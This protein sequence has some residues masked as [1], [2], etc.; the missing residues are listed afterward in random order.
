MMYRICSRCGASLDPE[1]KCDCE[2]REENRLYSDRE[3]TERRNEY[4]DRPG[5][6]AGRQDDNIPLWRR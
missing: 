4:I 1:E 5:E 3:R 6:R 2:K